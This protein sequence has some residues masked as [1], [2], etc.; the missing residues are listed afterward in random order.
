MLTVENALVVD[1]KTPSAQ[2]LLAIAHANHRRP[3]CGCREDGVPMYVA[4]TPSGFVT[5][6]M[7]GS[8]G[9]HSVDCG[10]WEPPAA[11]SG[12]GQ[13]TGEAISVNPDAGTTTLRLG[14]ALSR[15]V[16]RAAPEPAEDGGSD[17]AVSDGTKLTLRALLHYLWD[18]AGLS[19][20]SPAMAGK[21]NW[22]VVSWYL[23]QAAVGKQAKRQALADKL[24]VPEP[25]D[26]AHK[27]QVAARRLSVW[28]GA[29]AAPGKASP[30]LVVVGECKAIEPARYG[31]KVVVKHMPDAPLLLD[32]SIHRRLMKR[33]AGDLELW[34]AHESWHLMTIATFAVGTAG[35]AT[36][37]EMAV[38]VV[39]EHWLPIESAQVGVVVA[40]AV[41]AQRRFRIGLRY[42]LSASAASAALVFSD[43]TVPTAAFVLAPGDEDAAVAALVPQDS[44]MASW[45]WRTD[46]SFP[47]LPCRATVS[48]RKVS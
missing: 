38:M 32:D 6:R 12:L 28:S 15:S 25:F 30:L 29:Q 26:V 3:L 43:T 42:N 31:H 1:P 33:F 40:A 10:S 11:L 18:E 13:V 16:G 22:R 5:K 35:I 39:D 48:P 46:D 44:G 8:G 14:F 20:W 17:T 9:A 27:A 37:Q 21:R 34:E 4:A 41:E 47:E 36:V 23:R 19:S 24:F 2:A 7:P 45:L